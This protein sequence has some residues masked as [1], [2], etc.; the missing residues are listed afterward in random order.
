MAAAYGRSAGPISKGVRALAAIV[1]FN[2]RK[3]A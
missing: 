1:D 2:L 3:S